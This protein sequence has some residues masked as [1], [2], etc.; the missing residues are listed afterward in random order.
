[1]GFLV[2]VF[3]SDQP[4]SNR[5]QLFCG[6]RHFLKWNRVT[7]GAVHESLLGTLLLLQRR[8]L[9]LVALGLF[10]PS[11]LEIRTKSSWTNG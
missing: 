4:I 9:F 2:L 6:G 10:A 1:M 5:F 8:S 7:C 11:L 3:S